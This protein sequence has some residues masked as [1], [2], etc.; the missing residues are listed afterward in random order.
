MRLPGWL[1]ALGIVAFIS[2][3]MTL[4]VLCGTK[5]DCQSVAWYR[6]PG[7][8]MA[9]YESLSGGLIA[10]GGALFAGW[11]A[12]SAVRE[13]VEIE[14]R[15]LRAADIAAQSLRSDQVSK[16]V[17]DLTTIFSSGQMLLRRI[18]EGLADPYPFANQF[19]KL[20]NG[21]VF[22]TSSGNWTSSL[23]GDE[24]WNLVS[25]MRSIAQLLVEKIDRDNGKD[26]NGT[27][28]L[29]NIA[30]EQAVTEFNATLESVR[31]MLETQRTWLADENRRLA[32][33]R[34]TT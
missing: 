15:K 12:W 8:S 3:V 32:E 10:A 13:Q 7:C 5:T 27:M 9:L 18:R 24:V 2:V 19:L 17:A 6:L 26:Y 25:R 21:Q 34:Q 1:V 20:W 16:V 33:L 11:L 29:A 14:R 22:P 28:N 4:A 30:A 31:G 23:T